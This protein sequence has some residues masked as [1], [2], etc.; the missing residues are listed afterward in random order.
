MPA[1]RKRSGRRSRPGAPPP[2]RPPL[3][4]ALGQ[5]HLRSPASA[6]PLVEF[7]RPA[8]RLVVEIGA[9]GGMLT[10]ELLAAGATVLALEVDP[11][12][13]ATLGERIVDRRLEVRVGDALDFDW[14]SLPA[15]TLVAGNLPYN[16]GTAIVGRVLRSG[17]GIERAAFLLQRDV[18]E[19]MIAEPGD[20]AYGALSVLI[21][22]RAEARRLGIV[23]PGAF[24]PPPKVDSAFVG[25]TLREPPPALAG[26]GGDLVERFVHTAFGQ[27]RK[28]LLNA[29]SS[30]YPRPE[31]ARA[32]ARRGWPP[33]VRAETLSHLELLDLMARLETSPRPTCPE[34]AGRGTRR[35]GDV[36]RPGGT[37]FDN[38]NDEET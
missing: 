35:A 26:E 37:I 17:R 19:R 20:E 1:K 11:D 38:R 8:G 16:V 3:R 24:V 34:T 15:G 13:A 14:S 29:L 23:K 21:R 32:I 36:A 10:G 18:V 12:W 5:H 27:R 33:S 22:L 7:L 31:V 6:R 4:K 2:E 28:T 25:L 30:A 9:G